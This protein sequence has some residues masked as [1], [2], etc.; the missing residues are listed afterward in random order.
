M[1]ISYSVDVV[2]SLKFNADNI[3]QLLQS[4]SNYGFIYYDQ[5]KDEQYFNPPIISTKEATD[6]ILTMDP[7][8]VEDGRGYILT[9]IDDTYVF[10]FIR[11]DQEDYISIDLVESSI[12]WRKE[13]WGGTATSKYAFD[14]ARY[15]R[16]ALRAFNNFK[17]YKVVFK[18]F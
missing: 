15:V 2:F 1:S 4:A 10:L 14:V 7:K 8:L 5:T 12:E 16:V 9:R 11:K 17:V 3:F 13:F 18:K 6:L